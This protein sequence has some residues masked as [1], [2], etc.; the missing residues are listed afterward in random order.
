MSFLDH[1]I[2]SIGIVVDPSKVDLVLHK[3]TLKSIT[4]IQSFLRLTGYYC[5]FI[6]GFS[7]LALS[8]TQLMRKGHTFVWDASSEEK[9]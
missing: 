4:E 6:K 2:S 1:V 5:R 3:E 7:K 8:L 9:I